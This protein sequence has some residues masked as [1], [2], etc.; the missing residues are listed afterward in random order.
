VIAVVI[1]VVL[2]T[3]IG[4]L[5]TKKRRQFLDRA[6][7]TEA[8]IAIASKTNGPIYMRCYPAPPIVYEAAVRVRTGKPESILLWDAPKASRPAA[9]FCWGKR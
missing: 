5:W 1:A 4:Y 8:L 2:V 6:A 3:N 7:P 9:E